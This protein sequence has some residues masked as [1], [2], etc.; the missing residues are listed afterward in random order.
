MTP[1]WPYW[2]RTFRKRKNALTFSPVVGLKEV[3]EKVVAHLQQ[4]MQPE[5]RLMNSLL[6]TESDEEALALLAEGIDQFGDG[7]IGIMDSVGQML[8]EQGQ[9]EM[10][11]KIAFLREAA[12]RQLN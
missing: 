12:I 9:T 1:S 4:N 11:Q 7:L 10:A 5:L 2:Q 8:G 3:Y 6:T